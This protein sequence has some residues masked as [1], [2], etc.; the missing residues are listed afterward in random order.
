MYRQEIPTHKAA[1]NVTFASSLRLCVKC[2]REQ[3]ALEYSH[4]RVNDA[5]DVQLTTASKSKMLHNV[6]ECLG[7]RRGLQRF[8]E[9][10]QRRRSFFAS[11]TDHICQCFD[12][13]SA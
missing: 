12:P 9:H 8:H 4:L 1:K 13:F 10:K 2:L 5:E 11:P 6:R 3:L 7:F